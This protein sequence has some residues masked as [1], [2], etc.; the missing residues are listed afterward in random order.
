LLALTNSQ[1]CVSVQGAVSSIGPGGTAS[2]DV[3]VSVLN[4]LAAGVTVS[5]SA[6]AG[7]PSI[8]SGCPAGSGSASCWIPDLNLLG[9]PASRQLQAQVRAGTGTSSVTLTATA[10]VVLLGFTP[11]SAAATVLVI[12]PPPPRSPAPGSTGS[13]AP[14]PSGSGGR[15]SG[16]KAPGSGHSAGSGHTPGSGGHSPGTGGHSPGSVGGSGSL[17]P[18]GSRGAGQDVG[19]PGPI[20]LPLDTA[21]GAIATV[22]AGSAATLFPQISSSAGHATTKQAASANAAL[23]GLPLTSAALV[24]GILTIVAWLSVAF[25]PRYRRWRARS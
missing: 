20:P 8:T 1:L 3:T 4:G 14:R 24:L 16:S 13:T 10:S 11:P 19:A 18:G 2:Y 12:T 22:G 7:S 5:L 21:P 9:A 6:D 15:S 23:G 25:G 17:P